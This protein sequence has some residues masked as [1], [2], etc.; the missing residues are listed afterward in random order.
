MALFFKFNPP[1]S[2]HLLPLPEHHFRLTRNLQV[3]RCLA[4]A[5]YKLVGR[6]GNRTAPLA[7]V[8]HADRANRRNGDGVAICKPLY[9]NKESLFPLC[10]GD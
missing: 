5:N 7:E 3:S 8:G 10:L 6:I 4:A 2:N 9:T 1:R